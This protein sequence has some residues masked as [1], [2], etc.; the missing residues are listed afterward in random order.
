MQVKK[1]RQTSSSISQ[2]PR[3]RIQTAEGVRRSLI[4]QKKARLSSSKSK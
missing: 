2:P 1:S 4:K 3:K